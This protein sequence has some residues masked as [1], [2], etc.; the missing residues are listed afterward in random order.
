MR[1]SPGLLAGAL[2]AELGQKAERRD[3][4]EEEGR[5]GGRPGGGEVW[6]AAGAC[7][8][9][10]AMVLSVGRLAKHYLQV[11]LI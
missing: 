9:E 2:G 11:H 1:G 8:T 3:R 10:S 7:S 6:G 4:E 5:R